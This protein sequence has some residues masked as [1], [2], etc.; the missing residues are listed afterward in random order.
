MKYLILSIAIFGFLNLSAQ[1][2]KGF[3]EM[4]SKYVKGTISIVA[5]NDVITGNVIFLDARELEEYNVSH[6]QNAI[7]V[8]FD[9]FKLNK[10]S[11]IDKNANVVVYCSIGYRSEKIGEKLV[12]EGF[13]NV[14]NLYGGIFNW[15]NNGYPVYQNEVETQEVHGYSESWSKWLNKD[16]VTVITGKKK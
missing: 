14:K 2:P 15:T 1:N 4:T 10:L 8:G 5:P 13:T 6:I 3:D 9:D 7:Y 11:E 12:K 16:K